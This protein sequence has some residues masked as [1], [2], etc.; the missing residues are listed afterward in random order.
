MIYDQKGFIGERYNR[1]ANDRCIRNV[2]SGDRDCCI[3]AESTS[4]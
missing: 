3:E 2:I 4:E 1:L